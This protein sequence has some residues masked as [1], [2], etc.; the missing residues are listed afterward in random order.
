MSLTG[1][2]PGRIV[3]QLFPVLPLPELLMPPVPRSTRIRFSVLGLSLLGLVVV[4]CGSEAPPAPP[5]P[6]AEARVIFADQGDGAIVTPDVDFDLVALV[7]GD[8]DVPVVSV[9]IEWEAT[10]GTINSISM[11]DDAGLAS[12][13]WRLP[14]GTVPGDYMATA[15]VVNRVLSVGF[16]VTLPVSA[17]C[18]N[19]LVLTDDFEGVD[20]WTV[21]AV[22]GPGSSETH[23][24]LTTGGN[25]D[26]YRDMQHLLGATSN[27]GVYHLF[28]AVYDPA[29]SG[30]IDHINY[31]EDREVLTPPFVGAAVG[32]GF[33][34]MQNGN[35]YASAT[36]TGGAFNST[37]WETATR[38]DITA[39][40]VGGANF[41]ANAPPLQFGYFRTNT[42]SSGSAEVLSH[43]ID[44]WQVEICR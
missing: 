29:V 44:N 33:M 42:N 14:V 9:R 8:N 23:Q 35:R 12:T 1:P 18:N 25:P 36:M 10:E 27:I 16:T 30:A 4:N 34:V 40:Q 32:T 20:H 19:P 41:K 28:D 3:R 37:T 31:Q 6:Q 22:P 5:D 17:T 39:Q 24:L 13:T 15:T 7:L 11:T 26:G 2:G 38:N 43:G 21:T